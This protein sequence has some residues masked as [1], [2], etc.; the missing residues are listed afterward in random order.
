MQANKDNYAT[1]FKL[2]EANRHERTSKIQKVSNEN[3]WLKY[4]ED[5]AW[6]FGYNELT[7]PLHP[8]SDKMSQLKA[9]SA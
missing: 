8:A 7:V 3:T 2:Y 1:A 4:D 9:A 5:P 6:C